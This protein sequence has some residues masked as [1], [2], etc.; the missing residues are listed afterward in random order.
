M[1]GA[2]TNVGLTMARAASVCEGRLTSYSACNDV[3]T[4]FETQVRRG[5]NVWMNYRLLLLGLSACV[6]AV[7]THSYSSHPAQRRDR[8]LFLVTS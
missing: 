5:G 2:G 7:K 1:S 4:I 3:L 6:S 8:A